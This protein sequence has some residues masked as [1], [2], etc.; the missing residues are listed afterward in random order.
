MHKT[1]TITKPRGVTKG[2]FF[3]QDSFK[4]DEEKGICFVPESLIEGEE[5][6][7]AAY[8][9]IGW[10]R[11]NCGSQPQGQGS[12]MFPDMKKPVLEETSEQKNRIQE[13]LKWK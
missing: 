4:P 3:W 1:Y 7:R 10:A 8:L 13:F 2:R 5:L 11:T 9:E 6:N 12:H